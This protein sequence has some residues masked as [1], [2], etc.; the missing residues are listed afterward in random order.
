MYPSLN[1]YFQ[2]YVPLF[3]LLLVCDM[4]GIA[5]TYRLIRYEG[6]IKRGI[7]LFQKPLSE[8]L[9]LFLQ[10]LSANLLV[11]REASFIEELVISEAKSGEVTIG[12][13]R[14]DSDER[15]IH[16][17]KNGWR[18]LWPYVVYVNLNQP[19]PMLE[20]RVSLPMNLV[21][22]WLFLLT[23]PVPIVWLLLCGVIYW[24]Y[25]METKAIQEFLQR[26]QIQHHPGVVI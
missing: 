2:L 12:F 5:D 13:I 26:Q 22:V 7:R 23:I 19:V 6:K 21:F 25:H 15:L 17:G 11:K 10:A 24:N 4:W 18:T 20:Y 1:V 8:D 3:I 16:A 9:R 14:V